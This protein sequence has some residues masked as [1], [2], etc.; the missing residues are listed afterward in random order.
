MLRGEIRPVT[1]RVAIPIVG[2]NIGQSTWAHIPE[3]EQ[4]LPLYQLNL[5]REEMEKRPRHH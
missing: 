1:R 5:V 2:P 4:Q 3:Q